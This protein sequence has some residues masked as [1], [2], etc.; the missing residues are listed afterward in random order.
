MDEHA[1][2][3]PYWPGGRPTVLALLGIEPA[4]ASAARSRYGKPSLNRH[5]RGPAPSDL[6]GVETNA[7]STRRP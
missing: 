7:W 4:L 5:P 1:S 2:E 6:F 3:I